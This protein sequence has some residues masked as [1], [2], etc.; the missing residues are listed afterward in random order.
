[1][2]FLNFFVR[3]A[4]QPMPQ[5]WP[6]SQGGEKGCC[7]DDGCWD[8]DEMKDEGWPVGGDAQSSPIQEEDVSHSW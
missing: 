4:S 5:W 3:A 1:L 6:I 7:D 2:G 8:D